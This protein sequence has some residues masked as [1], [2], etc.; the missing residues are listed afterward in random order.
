MVGH[1]IR[2]PNVAFFTHLSI[3][4]VL[5]FVNRDI[6]ERLQTTQEYQSLMA[7]LN[8]RDVFREKNPHKAGFTVASLFNNLVVQKDLIKRSDFIFVIDQID[9]PLLQTEIQAN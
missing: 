4:A 2:H 5:E 8:C 7:T 1:L 9:G 6:G 3:V